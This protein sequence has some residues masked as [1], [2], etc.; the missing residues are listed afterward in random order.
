MTRAFRL[1]YDGGAYHGFQRQPDVPTVEDALFT[2]IRALDIGTNGPQGYTAAGRTDAGVSA[3]AQTV[4]FT[5]PEWC[6][7]RALNGELPDTV[8]S[9]A[10]TAE[11]DSFHATHDAIRREYT[12]HCYAPE[13]DDMRCRRAGTR[14]TGEHDFHNLTTDDRGT[15]RDLSIS[16]VRD[17]DYLIITVRSDGFPRGLVRRLVSLVRAVGSGDAPLSK[18]DQVLGPDPIDGPLG[19]PPAPAYPLVL[20]AVEYEVGFDTDSRAVADTRDRFGDHRIEHTTRARVADTIL[21][22]L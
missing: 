18:V 9:W 21:S 20:T 4:A 5:C 13:L 1:A 8:R 22:R 7:P 17:G 14:L 12:Y 10:M 6:T 19:V 3:V 2:A 16:T 15:V 11:L